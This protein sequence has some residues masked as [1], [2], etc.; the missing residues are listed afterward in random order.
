MSFQV[1]FVISDNNLCSVRLTLLPNKKE[2]DMKKVISAVFLALLCGTGTAMAA[3]NEGCNTKKF[4]LGY[5]GVF[6][7]D[8]LQGLSTRYWFNNNVGGELNLFYGNVGLR[9]Q[10]PP[11]DGNLDLFYASAK[12]L[13]APV[14]K[15]NSRFYFGL[16]GGIGS[17]GVENND[18]DLLP[19]D[20][21]VYTISPLIGAEFR[22]SEIP[23][24]CFNWEVGYKFQQISWDGDGPDE[25]IDVNIDGTFVTLGA[26]YYF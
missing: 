26:H 2:K 5:E 20:I 9:V 19:G 22:F 15:Q 6:A 14:V 21:S 24:L 4:S 25:E 12:L 18:V 8:I 17:V 11:I 1:L 23:D 7:G 3:E 13:Y 10:D 16:E